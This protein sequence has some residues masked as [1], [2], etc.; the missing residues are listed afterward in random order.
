MLRNAPGLAAIIF[1]KDRAC[2][3]DLLMRSLRRQFLL[4]LAPVTV[5]YRSTKRSFEQGYQR[6]RK[7][8]LLDASWRPEKDFSRDFVEALEDSGEHS[9]VTM[10]LVDDLVFTG[11]IASP[12]PILALSQ[13]ERV[14]SASTR[15]DRTYT[16]SRLP[17]F[18][19]EGDSLL[20]NW[21]T[22][23]PGTWGY[24]MSVDGN[25]FRTTDILELV[26]KLDFS[27]PNSLEGKMAMDA[28]RAAGRWQA[29]NLAARLSALLRPVNHLYR[30]RTHAV[31]YPEA[32]VFNCPLNLVSTES[33]TWHGALS[34]EGLND[35]YLAGQMIDDVPFYDVRPDAPHHLVE[36]LR[37]V[38]S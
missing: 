32:K 34:A 22:A 6:L 3:L 35:A 4:P 26:S 25:V 27:T 5:I 37:W 33:G 23:D 31:A 7:K 21:Q 9:S 13:D 15:Q 2:Q 38:R 19:Q 18:E 24:P 8:G 16:P 20:W 36:S 28:A 14:L 30:Q 11:R 10:L 29:P 17:S 1:T 12:Q